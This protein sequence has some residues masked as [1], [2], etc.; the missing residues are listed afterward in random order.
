MRLC[1]AFAENHQPVVCFGAQVDGADTSLP[2][3]QPGRGQ[4]GNN[5]PSSNPPIGKGK[6]VSLR[7]SLARGSSVVQKQPLWQS[8]LFVSRPCRS[9]LMDLHLTALL[10]RCRCVLAQGSHATALWALTMARAQTTRTPCEFLP[11]R[12]VCELHPAH[13]RTR[14]TRTHPLPAGTGPQCHT[15]LQ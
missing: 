14:V 11:L 4:D 12:Y 5:P 9:M 2:R 7:W 1:F 8:Y 15:A 13:K 10:V 3:G 6:K